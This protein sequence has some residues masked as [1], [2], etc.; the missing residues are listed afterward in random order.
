MGEG[1]GTDF[2]Q[3]ENNCLQGQHRPAPMRQT[4]QVQGSKTAARTQKPKG[5]V[6]VSVRLFPVVQPER[7]TPQRGLVSKKIDPLFSINQV[8]VR[9][10]SDWCFA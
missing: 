6:S 3:V 2:I 5:P 9:D 8:Q 1:I 10:Q 4:P 7:F